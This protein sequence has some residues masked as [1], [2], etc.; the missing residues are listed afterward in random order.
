[1]TDS[2]SLWHVDSARALTL[3][4]SG[5]A[6]R[7]AVEQGRVWLTVTGTAE[8]PAED[9]WL[10]AGE[11]LTLEPCQTAVV[12]GWPSADFALLTPPQASARR[13]SGLLGRRLFA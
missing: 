10:E 5:R 12:E 1:M 7:L 4:P 6:R 3:S 11:A 9:R 8:R 2:Q 13:T